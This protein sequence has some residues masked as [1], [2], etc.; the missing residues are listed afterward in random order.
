MTIFK[1]GMRVKRVRDPK[2]M[3]ACETTLPIGAEG[4]VDG[5]DDLHIYVMPDKP[6]TFFIDPV[7]GCEP[8]TLEPILPT[9][10]KV[11]DFIEK[12]N[13]LGREP[14]I[15]APSPERDPERD[16]EH[17]CSLPRAFYN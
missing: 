8:E 4:M 10:E 17:T 1:P 13:K 14:S 9:D 15:P 16:P 12:L 6:N 7:W 5:A 3:K 11:Q 2:F